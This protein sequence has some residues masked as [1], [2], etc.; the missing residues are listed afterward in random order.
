VGGAEMDRLYTDVE[1]HTAEAAR[2]F[3]RG[4]GHW[5]VVV[6]GGDALTKRVFVAVSSAECPCFRSAIW[7]TMRGCDLWRQLFRV[8]QPG[9]AE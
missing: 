3:G 5:D 7:P 2:R 1:T 8:R 9:S 4:E 6:G